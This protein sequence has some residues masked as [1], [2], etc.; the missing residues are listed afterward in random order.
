VA[1]RVTRE[2]RWSAVCGFWVVAVP[3]VF[4]ALFAPRLGRDGA[5]EKHAAPATPP[6]APSHADA[7]PV[8]TAPPAPGNTPDDSDDV[9]LRRVAHWA[10]SESTDA[11][12]RY[13]DTIRK[14]GLG[15]AWQPGRVVDPAHYPDA[16]RRCEAVRRALASL[17]E[18][19]EQVHAG[20]G[21]RV[22]GS[23]ASRPAQERFLSEYAVQRDE[24]RAAHRAFAAGEAKLLAE[25]E[26]LLAFLGGRAGT[27]AMT[28]RDGRLLFR[29]R[30]DAEA[31]NG[32]VRRLAN[33][34]AGRVQRAADHRGPG[35]KQWSGPAPA[36]DA[37]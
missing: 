17:G 35:S 4:A 6:A 19:V 10:V 20:L 5:A 8:I 12:L 25:I 11:Y 24:A 16:R 36:A 14:L 34:A 28:V 7:L 23:G 26:S 27:G 15:E 18:Q 29:D 2:K 32:H 33:A 1:W 21:E 13:D 31:F 30:D 3:L 37:R 9:R 22:R